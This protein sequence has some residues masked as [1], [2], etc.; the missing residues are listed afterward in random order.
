M[1]KSALKNKLHLVSR[2]TFG[3]TPQDFSTLD[4]I[5]LAALQEQIKIQ[6]SKTPVSL[7]VVTSDIAADYRNAAMKS[8]KQLTPEERRNINRE[9]VLKL[10]NLT[11]Q[12][13]NQMVNGED[14]LREKMA[15]FWHGHF[16][17]RIGNTY[18][19]QLLLDIIRKNALENFGDLLR[20]V[21]KSAAMLSF[22]NNQQ[23]RKA[24]PNENF[25]REV[26]ELFT[27]GR[28]NYTETDV[29]QGARAFTGW[30]YDKDSMFRFN[31]RV[32]DTGVKTFLGRTGNFNGDD[33]LNML[34]E[35][36]DCA[37]FITRK[38]YRYFVNDTPDESHVNQLAEKFYQSNYNIGE[39]MEHI[40]KSDW[41]YD[42][43]NI[44][45]IIKSPVQ[46][47]VS[48]QRALPMYIENPRVL[49]VFN[50]ALGQQPFYPPNVA[51]WPGG[52]SWIDSS[53]LMLRLKIPQLIRD[54][55]SFHITTKT[56]D[57]VQMGGGKI[58]DPKEAARIKKGKYKGGYNVKAVINWDK[59]F[60]LFNNTEQKDL[61]RKI[62]EM[63]LA[64]DRQPVV[65]N[66]IKTKEDNGDRQDYIRSVTIALMSTPEFQ[67]C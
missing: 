46:L 28:G 20:E 1:V 50:N 30:M 34:L 35:N 63:L 65:E 3:I 39:L 47:I 43:D 9:N 21:S 10:Q 5:S 60:A 4:N 29:K 18:Q 13:M 23:N 37:Q 8:R 58:T 19:Q 49:L 7:A 64:S 42:D 67:L 57:D 22:L 44:G 54:D 41:F 6:S 52:T 15:L 53:S 36:K 2:A 62:S 12:W 45:N 51:G 40:F 32:H 17:C 11:L 56:D 25:A 38:I 26:M 66:A 31:E 55:A 59:Y 27:L 14:Q 33:I 24:H 61:Y 16:A 48:I